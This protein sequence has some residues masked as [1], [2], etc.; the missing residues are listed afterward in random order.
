MNKQKQQNAVSVKTDVPSSSTELLHSALARE[1]IEKGLDPCVVEKTIKEKL[2]Q[3][4]SGYCS[5]EELLEDAIKNT[6]T[7]GA[8]PLEDKGTCLLSQNN[9]VLLQTQIWP[10]SCNLIRF[11]NWSRVS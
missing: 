7:S 9:K 5:L 6:P 10:H 8:A 2:R 4:G 1:A 3:T 11:Q